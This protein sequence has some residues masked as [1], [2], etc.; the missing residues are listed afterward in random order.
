MNVLLRWHSSL[1]AVC[2]GILCL[3]VGGASPAHA[4]TVRGNP[5]RAPKTPAVEEASPVQQA[6]ATEPVRVAVNSQ[7]PAPQR[8]APQRPAARSRQG[9]TQPAAFSYGS[10]MPR[11]E[12]RGFVPRH[13]LVSNAQATEELVVEPFPTD[14]P[15]DM[16]MDPTMVP[17]EPLGPDC[18][19]TPAVANCGGCGTSGGCLIPC[20]LLALDNIEL[21]AGT[22]AFSGPLNMGETAS[23]GFHYGLN[24]GVPAPCMPNQPI[25]MQ[26]GYRGVSSNYSGASFT[27]DSRNQSF[28]TAGLFRRVDWGL[29]G[30]VVVDILSDKWYYDDLSLTQLR[31]ELSWVFP[32]C[33]ELG[34]FFAAGTKT[35]DMASTLW[36][37]GQQRTVIEEYE[38]TDLI[39]FF[40]RRRFEAVGNGNGRLF[41]G[42]TGDGGGLVGADFDLPMTENWALKTGFTY[43]IP[44]DG[45][46][47]VA[48]LEEAWN[49][50]ISLVWYPGR[51]KA[52]GNDYFRPLFDV[53]DNGVFIPRP[54]IK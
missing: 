23:F 45:N 48:Y 38:P 3:T 42:F 22:Q 5:L 7:P 41:A 54:S 43:L 51:R 18:V 30:G 11:R 26:L 25:G 8:P 21:F 52:V 17:D 19:G 39:A 27:E 33:H 47:R 53:A 46:N 13:E 50:G 49:V 24:W 20:P 44:K 40:Y 9:A 35:N 10:G 31:G 14:I 2:L 1:I 4:Q 32:Q 6:I 12:P 29:Q 16:T 37:N 36:V 15:G 34:A 28:I